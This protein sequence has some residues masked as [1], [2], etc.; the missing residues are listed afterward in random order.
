MKLALVWFSFGPDSDALAMSVRSFAANMARPGD[1]FTVFEEELHPVSHNVR[2]V[3]EDS[4]GAVFR[5]RPAI[6]NLN[7]PGAPAAVLQGLIA[8][9]EGHDAAAKLDSDLLCFGPRLRQ[10][11]ETNAPPLLGALWHS[12]APSAAGSVGYFIRRDAALSALARVAPSGGEDSAITAAVAQI[13]PPL[14]VPYDPHGLWAGWRYENNPVPARYHGTFDHV[15]F[16][17]PEKG[18]RERR[19]ETMARVWEDS[20]AGRAA[21]V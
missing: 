19:D 17:N 13:S 7:G 20:V 12:P 3:L 9:S 18:S 4:F 10:M 6:R 14:L 15:G 16:G 1:S 2:M 11:F 21:A 5:K 8:A